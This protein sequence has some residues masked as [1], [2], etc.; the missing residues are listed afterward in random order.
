MA[1]S[2]HALCRVVCQRTHIKFVQEFLALHEQSLLEEGI[3]FR[4]DTAHRL[5][6][7]K[8]VQDGQNLVQ[9]AHLNR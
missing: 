2:V 4:N 9:F 8:A 5:S 3:T 1:Q 7:A 6:L